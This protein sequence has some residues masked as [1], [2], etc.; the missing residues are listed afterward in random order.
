MHSLLPKTPTFEASRNRLYGH[1]ESSASQC[2]EREK[3]TRSIH[4]HPAG[5]E[6]LLLSSEKTYTRKIKEAI[7]AQRIEETFEKEHILFLYLNQIYLGSGAYGV[8]AAARVHFDK[9]VEIVPCRIS[10]HCWIATKTKRLFSTPQLEKSRAR[11]FMRSP[12]CC[13]RFYN[14]RRAR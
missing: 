13:Q 14:S 3:S 12:K 7:L 10:D 4:N 1:C 11:Q 8:E 5:G 9:H 6:E 2:T